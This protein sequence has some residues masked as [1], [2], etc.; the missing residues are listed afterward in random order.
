MKH[1]INVDIAIK[2]GVHVAAIM[3][4]FINCN[5]ANKKDP[6]GIR[7]IEFDEQDL[8]EYFSYFT[9]KKI[10]TLLKKCVSLGLLIAH[11]EKDFCYSLRNS[12]RGGQH[13]I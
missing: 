9:P 5:Y 3:D 1:S 11:P 4:L 7:W 10:R 13:D 2:F 8:Y 6:Q 12:Q